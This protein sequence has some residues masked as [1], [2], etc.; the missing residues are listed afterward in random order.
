MQTLEELKKHFI[1]ELVHQDLRRV[2]YTL[3]QNVDN[4]CFKYD[5][6]NLLHARYITASHDQNIKGI[7]SNEDAR[8]IFNQLNA[9]LLDFINNLTEKD[10]NLKSSAATVSIP[11]QVSD[12]AQKTK[13]NKGKILYKVP[14]IM[15]LKKE[16]KCIIRIAFDEK[17]LEVNN[18]EEEGSK[19]DSIRI[20]DVMEVNFIDQCPNAAFNIRTISSS[21]Q[22][23]DRGDFTEWIFYVEP[24]LQGVY[25]LLLKVSVIEKRL[26]R[27]IRKDIVMEKKIEV[28]NSPVEKKDNLGIYANKS[29]MAIAAGFAVPSDFELWDQPIV[30][31][32]FFLPAL[33][34][35]IDVPLPPATPPPYP[36]INDPES[37][38]WLA[39][40]SIILIGLVIYFSDF[41]LSSEDDSDETDP[42]PYHFLTI[43]D[44]TDLKNDALFLAIEG[45]SPPF[46]LTLKKEND[47]TFFLQKKIN[48]SG[49]KQFAFT[50]LGLNQGLSEYFEAILED[51]KDSLIVS[52]FPVNWKIPDE[53]ESGENEEN[54]SIGI[55]AAPSSNH[56][57]LD[58]IVTN[59][60][61]P[62]LVTIINKNDT[63]QN[64][65]LQMIK[66][67]DTS[68][69]F[70]SLK[71]FPKEGNFMVE[72][73]DVSHKMANDNFSLTMND[74]LTLITTID[75]ERKKLNISVAGNRPPFK[76]YLDNKLI[77]NYDIK[78]SNKNLKGKK[79]VTIKVK[80]KNGNS[81]TNLVQ[82]DS[83]PIAPSPDPP[84]IVSDCIPPEQ[85][86]KTCAVFYIYEASTPQNWSMKTKTFSDERVI[87]KLNSSYTVYHLNRKEMDLSCEKGIYDN[88]QNANTFIFNGNN[89]APIPISN[90]VKP[91]E[92]LSYLKCS[93]RPPIPPILIPKGGD[94]RK[95]LKVQLELGVTYRLQKNEDKKGFS[96][97]TSP[98]MYR[99][100]VASFKEEPTFNRFVKK[101]E[102][103]GETVYVKTD[104]SHMRVYLGSFE[105]RDEALEELKKLK[106]NAKLN[107]ILENEKI[108]TI[109][110]PDVKI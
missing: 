93:S 96:I 84:I 79:K 14:G 42:S 86:K 34:P 30:L 3:R 25:D 45:S 16:R 31:D 78:F 53:N 63:S 87:K 13:C 108:P 18:L 54:H 94:P 2:F 69:L 70:Q 67:R 76:V 43:T 60:F 29:K 49:L 55:K 110:V 95:S 37:I 105:N 35:C 47:T 26:G 109:L 68:L 56:K 38:A 8:L 89:S 106:R 46:N 4:Q 40:A 22:L 36:T 71:N 32:S 48:N 74:K 90:Y 103:I 77:K 44:T 62:F 41:T 66:T 57:N 61:F 17:E 1:N 64:W 51:S 12:V 92:F 10:L 100:Q 107:G 6:L 73:S 102:N 83:S 50:S 88:L 101:L 33:D 97:I 52:K 98:E 15:E 58:M 5:N 85:L 91:N 24:L 99:V 65:S 9:S 19:I 27:E 104:T 75:K 23:V 80:D 59:G 82:F 81:K 39:F 21:E 11:T 72:V 28:V 7:L 20:A